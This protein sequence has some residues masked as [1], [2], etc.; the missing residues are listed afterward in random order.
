MKSNLKNCGG[1]SLS[2]FSFPLFFCRLLI[3]QIILASDYQTDRIKT[4]YR[5]HTIFIINQQRGTKN[6]KHVF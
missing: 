5:Q 6:G 1:F 3:A 2:R 4:I